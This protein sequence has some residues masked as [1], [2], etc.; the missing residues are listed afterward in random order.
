M[1]KLCSLFVLVA[2][3]ISVGT[4]S[5][6]PGWKPTKT[7]ELVAPAN[8]GGGWDMLCRV[9]QKT[10]VDEK[11]VEKNVIVVNKPGGGGAVGWKYLEGKKGQGEFLAATSTLLML[12]NLL[13]SSDL[14]YKNF[15]PIAMLQAEWIA[16]AVKADSPHKGINDLLTAIKAN[17][18]AVPIGVGPTLGNNDHLV[19]LSL[20]K[21]FG[22]DPDRKSV[23]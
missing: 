23:V 3:V 9:V 17:P 22:I 2:L 15:N 4:L 6:T 8:P 19:F 18:S 13:G 21:N 5:A 1:K 11:L 14:T 7:I 20:A 16:V 12:N 10:L